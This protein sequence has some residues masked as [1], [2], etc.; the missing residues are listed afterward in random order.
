MSSSKLRLVWTNEEGTDHLVTTVA[1]TEQG[2]KTLVV[3]S[4]L[5]PSKGACDAALASGSQDG[6]LAQFE[7]LEELV[8]DR[9]RAEAGA[10]N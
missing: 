9:I 4:E 8:T 1:F 7:Q 5:H 3:M 6:A 10:S 2:G